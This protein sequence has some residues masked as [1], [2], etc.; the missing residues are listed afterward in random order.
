MTRGEAELEIM[1]QS[2]IEQTFVQLANYALALFTQRF[3]EIQ[4][5]NLLSDTRAK[6]GVGEQPIQPGAIDQPKIA[7]VA[8]VRAQ[9]NHTNLPAYAHREMI[10]FVV[11]LD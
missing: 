8:L 11:G 3:F 9:P 2:R 1:R 5:R 7:I 4:F 10:R 6:R